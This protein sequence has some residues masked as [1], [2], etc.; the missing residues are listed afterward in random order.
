MEA[1]Q[2]ASSVYDQESHPWLSGMGLYDSRVDQ[3]ADIAY[4]NALEKVFLPKLLNNL[5]LNLQQS[6]NEGDLYN[7]FRVYMMFNKLDHMDKAVVKAWFDENW[8]RN[9]RDDAETRA[10]LQQHFDNLF[11][12]SFPA[13]EL[14]EPLVAQTRAVLL[15]IPIAQRVYSRIKASSQYNKPVDMLNFYGDAVRTNYKIDERVR[16][17]MHIPVLFTIQ[18]YKNVDLSSGSPLIADLANEQWM[19][20]DGK[21]IDYTTLDSKEI[22]EQVK[23][24]YFADYNKI[25]SAIYDS[26]DVTN[27]SSLRE[28]S[29]ALNSFVDPVYSPLLSILQVGKLNTQ[30]TPTVPDKLA[31]KV[32]GALGNSVA[33]EQAA[34]YLASAVDGNAVDIRFHEL[35]NLLIESSRA[36]APINATIQRLSQLKE[37]VQEISMAPDPAK[38]SY[39]I[40]KARA[41]SGSG[42]PITALKGYAKSTPEPIQRWL[43][44]LADQAGRS[45]G[46]SGHQFINSAWKSQVCGPF[47]QTLAG[48]YPFNRSSTDEVA[49]LDFTAFFKPGGILDQFLKENM[50]SFVDARG[51]LLD[52][53]GSGFS[54]SAIAEIQKAIAIRNTFF[55]ENADMPSVSFELRPVSMDETDARFSLELGDQ[56]ITYTH[57]PKFWNTLSWTGDKESKRL[58][59]LFEDLRDASFDK[60]YSGPWVLFHLLD[61]A[62]IKSTGQSNTYSII[63]SVGGSP[64][65]PKTT[66]KIIYEGRANSVNNPFRSDLL[67]SFR[68]PESL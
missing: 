53:Q 26:L 52:T 51:N 65:D 35:N 68:C 16:T 42:N 43:L 10:Q 56:R 33:G 13:S 17:A 59:V 14:N 49:L 54:S 23:A 61:D 37:Y 63:F 55:R 66:H 60:I 31:E 8:S 50:Q 20:G 25:W 44:S 12:R 2:K 22:S 15:R 1:L 32:T 40:V 58:R 57:G 5:E 67:S 27:F 62:S 9:F 41:D 4:S 24:L 7:T 34:N 38:K 6:G 39:E 30:L 18:G 21:N 47:K 29:D 48:R 64:N 36:P 19:M 46:Q 3:A 45:V 28:L 11:T